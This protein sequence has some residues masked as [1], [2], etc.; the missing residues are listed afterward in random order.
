MLKH[1][2]GPPK[3]V[4]GTEWERNFVEWAQD[5]EKRFGLTGS[6]HYVL[7]GIGIL[8][9]MLWLFISYT[10]YRWAKALSRGASSLKCFPASRG[11]LVAA[12]EIDAIEKF[13]TVKPTLQ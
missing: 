12:R 8:L 6:A 9:S 13:A 2:D 5:R 4:S 3:G 1:H 7:L 11:T 10:R